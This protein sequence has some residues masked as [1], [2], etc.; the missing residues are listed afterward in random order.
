M[1]V[2]TT[3]LA[4]A[5]ADTARNSMFDVPGAPIPGSGIS[6]FVAALKVVGALALTLVL[7]VLAVWALKKLM[8]AAAV[9]SDGDIVTIIELRYLAPKKAVALVKVL[10]RVLIVGVTDQSLTS[11]GELTA[12]EA[13]TLDER[14]PERTD[15]GG[16]GAILASFRRGSG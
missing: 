8:G 15:G 5:V 7:M 13:A 16:F 9:R 2:G 11:L 4:A 12:E 6:L 14:K 3:A 1:I 10:D